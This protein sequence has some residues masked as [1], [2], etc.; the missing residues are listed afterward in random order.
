MYIE[1]F[2]TF[3]WNQAFTVLTLATKRYRGLTGGF[4]LLRNFSVAISVSPRVCFIL[5][6]VLIFYLSKIM[7]L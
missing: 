4:L 6:L 5:A 7:H 3:V 2:F 1:F